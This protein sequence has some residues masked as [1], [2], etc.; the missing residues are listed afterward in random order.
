M[1]DIPGF[2][3]ISFEEA[4]LSSRISCS[5]TPPTEL[6]APVKAIHGMRQR[7]HGLRFSSGSPMR[8]ALAPEVVRAAAA[9]SD[10]SSPIAVLSWMSSAPS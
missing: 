1:R 10:E 8:S 7:T 4:T 6:L 9:A 5:R 2:D 3:P